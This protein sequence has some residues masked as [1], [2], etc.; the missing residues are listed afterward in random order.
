MIKRLFMP[1]QAFVLGCLILFAVSLQAQIT[2]GTASMTEDAP[3]TSVPS[4]VIHYFNVANGI[5]LQASSAQPAEFTWRKLNTSNNS[6][7]FVSSSTG[8]TSD[9]MNIEE[10]CYEVSI[11]TGIT[12]TTYRAWAL[13]PELSGNAVAE[14]VEHTCAKLTLKASSVTTKTLTVINPANNTPYTIDYGMAYKWF[15]NDV[16]VKSDETKQQTDLAAPYNDADY[17]VEA[18][19]RF[20]FIEK[21][22]SSPI[23]VVAKAVKAHFE[24]EIDKPE[25]KNEDH[26][27]TQGSAPLRIAYTA[28]PNDT[29]DPSKMSEGKISA[30]TYDFGGAGKD[31]IPNTSYVFQTKGTYAVTLTVENQSAQCK[32]TF[33][34]V[35]FLVTD[36]MLDAPN[37]FT[38]TGDGIH[39]EFKVSYRSVKDFRMTIIN[40]W[41]RVVYESTNPAEGWD[42]KIAGKEAA[43]GVYYYD[44]V[45]TGF[46]KDEKKHIKGFLHLVR[47]GK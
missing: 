13:V 40:R 30:Y 44:A 11:N 9:L 22:V 15:A 3:Y 34:P 36:L 8:T 10:G 20:A 26:S 21:L 32:S 18:S 1:K 47:K 14:V 41:G 12:T 42:G 46:N 45:A 16:Q 25:H 35:S 33:G 38:P 27:D 24:Y 5:S 37:F 43:P 2:S 7:S 28:K 4:D 31:F 6:W 29:S 17:F 19:C 39:D 23:N